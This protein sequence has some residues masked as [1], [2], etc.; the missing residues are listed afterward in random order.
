MK[1]VTHR[2]D[3]VLMYAMEQ[4]GTSA[5]VGNVGSAVE[6][7]DNSQTAAAMTYANLETLTRLNTEDLTSILSSNQPTNH[8][9][10]YTDG[11]AASNQPT[12]GYI[13]SMATDL[14]NPDEASSAEAF[15]LAN[16]DTFVV[17]SRASEDV[18]TVDD[19]PNDNDDP[20]LRVHTYCKSSLRVCVSGTDTIDDV[21]E[22]GNPTSL[23]ADSVANRSAELLDLKTVL[24][25]P[26]TRRVLLIDDGHGDLEMAKSDVEFLLRGDAATVVLREGKRSEVWA[27]FGKIFFQGRK[28]KGYVACRA[29]NQVI[30]FDFQLIH[31]LCRRGSERDS[32]RP[33][34]AKT[35]RHCYLR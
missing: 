7:S 1:S 32:F 16:P 8:Q 18:T 4:N 5:D 30:F 26:T 20:Q 17:A 10:H 33:T 29:C 13:V 6:S 34:L 22:A 31:I 25:G 23:G 2:P 27:R 11:S 15:A 24:P 9:T 3:K 12:A 35:R 14:A 19:S 28:I 21:D